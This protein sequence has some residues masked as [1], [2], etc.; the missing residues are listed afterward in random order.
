MTK[1]F[2]RRI[3]DFVCGQCGAAV[4]GDGY[5][6]HCPHCL[7][8]R[9]VDVAPGDRL[10]TCGGMMRPTG[11][12]ATAKGYVLTHV[13]TVCGHTMRCRAG[14]QDD[15]AAIMALARAVAEGR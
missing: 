5:T 2:T 3:E 13:C 1:K 7:W 6:N 4:V 9:H 11:V 15:T 10:A 12:E 8:S 14:K